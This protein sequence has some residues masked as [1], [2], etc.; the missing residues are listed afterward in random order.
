M[1]AP[2]LISAASWRFDR[3]PTAWRPGVAWRIVSISPEDA[4]TVNESA[5]AKG[6]GYSTYSFPFFHLQQIDGVNNNAMWLIC[7]S[8][9]CP[10]KWYGINTK[11]LCF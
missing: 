4:N 5:I 8:G 9:H 3:L 1:Q 10:V 7:H 6:K 11:K 2:A